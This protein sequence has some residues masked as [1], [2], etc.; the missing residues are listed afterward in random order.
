MTRAEALPAVKSALG[1]TTTY[2]D[3]TL[4]VFIDEVFSYLTSAGIPESA[5]T[6]GVVSRGVSDLWDN[7]SGNGKLSGYFYDRAAQLALGR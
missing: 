6:G 5:I 2:Q 1:I 4:N 3:A 7:G